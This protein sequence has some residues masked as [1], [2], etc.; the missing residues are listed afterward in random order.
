[1][2]TGEAT[3]RR[4]PFEV[5]AG[6]VKKG[7]G[8]LGCVYRPDGFRRILKGRVLLVHDHVADQAHKMLLGIN[9]EFHEGTVEARLYHITDLALGLGYQDLQR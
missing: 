4:Y 5:F 6:R 7:R 3:T 2:G 8:P 9:A 1:M